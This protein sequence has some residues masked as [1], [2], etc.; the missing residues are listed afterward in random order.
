MLISTQTSF[1]YDDRDVDGSIAR[2][3]SWGFD[4]MDFNFDDKFAVS[5]LKREEPCYFEVDD[6]VLFEMHRPLREACLRHGVRVIQMHAPFPSWIDGN[7][8]VNR[9][10]LTV[11]EKC[12]ALCGYLNCPD[13]IIHPVTIIDEKEREFQ[14]SLELYRALIPAAK[15]YGVRICIENMAG[16]KQGVIAPTGCYEAEEA[17]R[18]IDILNE[19]AGEELFGFCFDVGHA[20]LYNMDPGEFIRT[21]GSRLKTLHLHDNDGIKDFHTIPYNHYIRDWSKASDAEA[22]Y[23]VIPRINW[24]SV[25]EGLKDIGY[26]GALNFETY[27]ATLAYPKEV[28]PEVMR[29]ISAIG[30]YWA[31]RIQAK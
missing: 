11:C 3:K 15:R 27:T 16:R 20:N 2:F 17:C 26:T 19:E 24:D 9:R 28:Q 29:L 1:W 6:E 31:G 4:A 21:V 12:L 18:C 5:D 7:E 13:L 30:R 22:N 10:M 14:T 25:V 8:D 23:G